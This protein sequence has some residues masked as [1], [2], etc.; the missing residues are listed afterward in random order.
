MPLVAAAKATIEAAVAG[1]YF[2]QVPTKEE[3]W[4]GYYVTAALSKLGIFALS[5][6]EA[7]RAPA[8]LRRG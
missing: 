3:V 2:Y 5:V 8:V 1:W 7:S 4:C 6:P